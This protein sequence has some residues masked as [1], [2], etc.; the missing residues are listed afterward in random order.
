MTKTTKEYLKQIENMN[1]YI[2]QLVSEVEELRALSQSL[3]GTQF[4]ER[5]KGGNKNNEA[6]FVNY[7]IKI[8]DLEAKI[9][10]EIDKF[11]DLKTVIISAIDELDDLEERILLRAKYISR[12]SWD[13]I[14][15]Q[16]N[17]SRS[18]TYRVHASALEHFK[19][20]TKVE[21]KR[22]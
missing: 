13:D 9:N 19:I 7:I 14:F 11:V 12:K 3:S 6:T 16:L 4:G 5:N 8:N 1:R 15:E 22:D 10:Q 18:A 17:R 21:M 2:E 20:P